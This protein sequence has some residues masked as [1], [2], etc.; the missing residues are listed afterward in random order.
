LQSQ[1][2][3]LVRERQAILRRA[4]D[5]IRDAL[6]DLDGPEHEQHLREE[7]LIA[8]EDVETRDARADEI[9]AP[10]IESDERLLL[11]ALS[12]LDRLYLSIASRAEKLA[13]LDERV[14]KARVFLDLLRNPVRREQGAHKPVPSHLGEAIGILQRLRAALTLLPSMAGAA[15]LY[16]PIFREP[17]PTIPK[18]MER[19]KEL[20]AGL[21]LDSKETRR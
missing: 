9:G 14:D 16:G 4:E 17:P 7:A 3:E 10:V 13:A 21:E 11:D 5:D 15:A 6:R 12:A 2:A 19:A 8:R 20:V 1:H 18:P